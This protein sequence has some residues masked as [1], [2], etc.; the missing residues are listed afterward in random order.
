MLFENHP[1]RNIHVSYMNNNIKLIFISDCEIFFLL[2]LYFL[3]FQESDEEKER[4]ENK[5]SD[6][7]DFDKTLMKTLIE[8]KKKRATRKKSRESV[9]P[10]K[11]R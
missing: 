8:S 7:E 9:T 5:E 3:S 1:L 11:A 10:T 2:A 4:E 6:S